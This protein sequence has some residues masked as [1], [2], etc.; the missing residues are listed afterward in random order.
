MIMPQ[1]GFPDVPSVAYINFPT[2]NT[3]IT[4]PIE[5][6]G[7][8][9]SQYMK[10]WRLEY[11]RATYPWPPWRSFVEGDV[12]VTNSVLGVFDPTGLPNGEYHIHLAAED[13]DGMTW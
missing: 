3:E 6:T 9:D 7:S 5:V 11:R 13:W 4:A 8:V 2:N 10:F 12:A 1:G